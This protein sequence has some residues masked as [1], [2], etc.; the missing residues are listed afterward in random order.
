LTPPAEHGAAIQASAATQASAAAQHETTAEHEAAA[1]PDA[2]AGQ[3]I[4]AGNGALRRK[5]V[6]WQHDQARLQHDVIGLGD[7]QSDTV[8]GRLLVRSLTRAQLGLSLM[9]L[10]IALAVIASLPVIMALLPSARKVTVAGLPLTLVI[11]GAGIFPV[12]MAVG[13][14]YNRQASQLE[15]RFIDLV[16]PVGRRLDA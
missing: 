12:L 15:A 3:G 9:C 4:P 10:A 14:F 16:D 13:W 6:V 5:V 8:Y 7:V 2:T 11:L 1:E